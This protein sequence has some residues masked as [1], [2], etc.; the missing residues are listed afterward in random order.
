MQNKKGLNI[1]HKTP[2]SGSAL[3][4]NTYKTPHGNRIRVLF[5]FA[6]ENPQNTL[7]DITD[8]L[9][10]AGVFHGIKNDANLK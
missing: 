3:S 10:Y 9:N 1:K 8:A 6:E 5:E 7:S 2:F 4:R